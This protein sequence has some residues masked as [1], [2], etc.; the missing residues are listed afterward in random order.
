M[1]ENHYYPFGL[2]HEFY[3]TATMKFA[4]KMAPNTNESMIVLEQANNFVGDGS[5]NYK[6]NGKEYQDELGLN[7][8]DYG[9]RNYDAAIGR[10]IVIDP[11]AEDYS[12]YS[13]YCYVFNDPM[14]HT[15]P[16]G[17]APDDIV[18]YGANNSSI[19]IKTKLID[20]SINASSIVGDFGGNYSFDGDGFVVTALDIV[21][22]IDPTPT[23]DLLSASLSAESGDWWGAGASVLGA[24]LPYAGDIAKGP[25]IAKGLDKINDAIKATDKAKDAKKVYVPKGVDGKTLKTEKTAAGNTKIDKE[26]KG[27]AHTQLREDKTG[28]YPQRTSFDSKGRKRADTHHTTHNE[29]GKTN[30]HKHTY[31]KNG[32]RSKNSTNE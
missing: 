2:K 9:A 10:W 6:Y 13:P 11:L 16:D 8:Y 1:E 22:V 26:A 29:K 31:Y 19:T 32:K 17:M 5:Y 12:D 3:N 21:G 27:K 25:K 28:N 20:V 24:A 14:R 4:E 7:M 30:P 15:D 18:I 23:S